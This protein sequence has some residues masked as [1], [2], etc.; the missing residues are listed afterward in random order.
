VIARAVLAIPGDLAT[1]TGGYAY[2]RQLLAGAKATGLDLVHWPLPGGW[3]NPSDA[4]LSETE[5]RLSLTPGGWPVIVDGLAL[6]AMPDRLLQTLRGPLVALCHHPLALETGL[7]RETAAHLADTERNALAHA[8]RV[9]TTSQATATTLVTDYGVEISRITVAPP[10]TELSRRST[11]SGEPVAQI[12]SVGSLV[13]RKGHDR[14]LAALSHLTALDWRLTIAGADDRDAAHA[15]ELKSLA[16]RVGLAGR[17]RFV[18]A[19]DAA[20]LEALWGATDIFAL[21]SR[22]EGFGMVYAEA[23]AHG[24]AVVGTTAGAIAEATMGAA[25]LV[26]PDDETALAAALGELISDADARRSLADMAWHAAGS[27]PRWPQTIECIARMLAD[28]EREAIHGLAD[29]SSA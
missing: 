9:I 23:I 27:L 11:C 25:V 10:G 22:H 4:G 28:I 13:P 8:A 1:P 16:R 24:V 7:D 6:G 20:T 29:A 15:A 18:G 17:V 21:A 26:D 14:L 12:L 2:A 5:R 3:P 19:A